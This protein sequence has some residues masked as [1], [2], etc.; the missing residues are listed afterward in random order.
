VIAQVDQLE[1]E[2]AALLRD[3]V[4]SVRGLLAEAAFAGRADDDADAGLGGGHESSWD[5]GS[6][7]G[8]TG[9]LARWIEG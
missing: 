1:G 2:V 5:S 9:R 8:R 4:D 6:M 7:D 3:L